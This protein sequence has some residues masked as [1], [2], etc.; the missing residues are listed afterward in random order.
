[1][2]VMGDQ[3]KTANT[4]HP[5]NVIGSRAVLCQVERAVKPGTRLFDLGLLSQR[6]TLVCE[7][8]C[9]PREEGRVHFSQSGVKDIN[10]IVMLA[11]QG[12]DEPSHGTQ[13]DTV[14]R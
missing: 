9:P 6:G 10:R 5:M 14:A 12:E 7:Y 2:T 11:E 8:R 13:L 1:M 3:V 4:D